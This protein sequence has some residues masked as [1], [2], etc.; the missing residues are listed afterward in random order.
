MKLTLRCTLTCTLILLYPLLSHAQSN[1]QHDL[2]YHRGT[3]RH[4]S[5]NEIDAMKVSNPTHYAAL[6]YY[7]TQSFNV[8]YIDCPDCKVDMESFYNQ[9]LFNIS[10][11]EALRLQGNTYSF[12][13]R[14][15]YAV[16]LKSLSDIVSEMGMAVNQVMSKEPRPLPLYTDT[17]NPE[18]DY[19]NYSLELRAWTYDFPEQYRLLTSEGN[20]LKLTIAQYLALS[21][22]R[23]TMLNSGTN[24]YILID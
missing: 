8:T 18:T 5:G 24:T 10:E 3:M 14:D 2:R 4:F 13:Y 9:D 22:E 23:L 21:P 20:V 15:R 1:P 12:I 17:G 11:H 6:L 7:F 16:T 19:Q